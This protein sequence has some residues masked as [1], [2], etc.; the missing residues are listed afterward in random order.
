MVKLFLQG[1]EEPIEYDGEFTAQQISS[2]VTAKTGLW[3]GNEH[4]LEEF[5]GLAKKFMI[6]PAEERKVILATAEEKKGAL[7]EEK[8]QT[9]ANL[10]V[11][12]MKKTLEKGDSFPEDET[13]RVKTLLP[14]KMKKEKKEAFEARLNILATFVFASVDAKDE[15]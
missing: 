8:Q 15:L 13:K 5:D 9:S 7:E 11:A 3:L 10:Y 6:A 14:K 1:Q 12:I 4:C 2:F